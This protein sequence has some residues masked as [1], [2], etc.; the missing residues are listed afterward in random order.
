M[1]K[2]K[3]RE[4]GRYEKTVTI[5]G[6]RIHFYGKTQSEVLNKIVEYNNKVAAGPLFSTV[7]D[8]WEEWHNTQ[9]GPSMQKTTKYPAK[10]IREHFEKECI[11]QIS[12]QM[13]QEHIY[14]LGETLSAKT[15]AKYLGVYL[16]VYDFAIEKGYYKNINP[17]RSVKIPRTAKKKIPREPASDHDTN[18][19]KQR[20]DLWLFPY[21]CLM[22][23]LRK[24]EALAIQGKDL[25]Y[26][27]GFIN[28]NKQILHVDN[29]ARIELPKTDAGI[30]KV[31]F[32]D[33]LQ[34][35]LPKISP[36]NFLFGGDKPLIY[37][38]Y[39]TLL[40]KYHAETNTTFTPHQLRHSYA[41][42]LYEAGLDVKQA[43][44]IMGHANESVTRDIY[45][46]ISERKRESALKTLNEFL[47][48]A[49]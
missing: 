41:T 36:E 39:H 16:G 20:T 26:D 15:L 14:E 8:E 40:E 18:I 21:F 23:G 33:E 17:A 3:K 38:R 25:D 48:K 29:S 28:I 46:H 30:R 34:K 45:T 2:Y 35:V 4:D 12:V 6:K 27:H 9:V 44:N 37:R 11:T 1:A 42:M 5:N 22:T 49:N 24:G 43:Q 31:P 47:E 32:L 10:R 13:I 19:I 7:L